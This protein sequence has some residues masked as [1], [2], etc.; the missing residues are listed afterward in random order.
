MAGRENKDRRERT[1]WNYKQ[2]GGNLKQAM[3]DAGYSPSYADSHAGYLWGIIGPEIEKAQEEIKSDKIKSVEE[4]QEWWSGNI[5]NDELDIK[6]RLK[7][8]ELLVRSQGG[9]QDNMK[10][11]VSA[12]LEDVL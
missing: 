1:I 4:I 2:N 3:I 12:K 11:N 5:D 9:F 10:L 8:S 7:S 6:D